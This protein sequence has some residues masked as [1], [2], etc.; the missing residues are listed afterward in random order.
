M[1]FFLPYMVVGLLADVLVCVNSGFQG[2]WAYVMPVLLFVAFTI[3]AMAV[4]L[5]MLCIISLF[6]DTSKP[7]ETKSHFYNALIKYALGFFSAFMGIRI[8][9][10]GEELIPEGRWLLVS[11]HRSIFDPITT[12]WALRRHEVAFISKPENLKLPVIG[13]Y[14]H[15]GMHLTIDRSDDRAALRTILTAADYIK[16]D[17]M[18]CAIYP[19]G[20]RNKGEGLLPF[21]NGAFKIAQKAKAPIVIMTTRYSG[22]VVKNF[23]FKKTDC[24]LTIHKVISTEDAAAMSTHDIGELVRDTMLKAI[25]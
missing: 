4:V 25:S 21:R 5:G 22:D 1:L 2:A 24:W 17:F 10:S 12:I 7:P 16:K 14:L 11:N 18:S 23:P 6:I 20:T 19:E 9:F 13:R 3:V 8:H 15:R